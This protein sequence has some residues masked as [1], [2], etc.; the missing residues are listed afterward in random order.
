MRP[1]RPR[2]SIAPPSAYLAG[3]CSVVPHSSA[4]AGT[5]VTGTAHRP[6]GDPGTLPRFNSVLGA[7]PSQSS[8]QASPKEDERW[9]ELGDL[10]NAEQM[11]ASVTSMSADLKE[12]KDREDAAKAAK[13]A[14]AKAVREA[15]K[16]ARKA[17]QSADSELHT[18]RR[19]SLKS[20]TARRPA[21]MKPA[22]KKPAAKN[23]NAPKTYKRSRHQVEPDEELEADEVRPRPI[24]TPPLSHSCTACTASR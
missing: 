2:R 6:E 14:A 12:K 22:A 19:S 18:I 24:P 8:S 11:A 10:D 16:G 1:A 13:A 3:V 21:A 15:K 5:N 7:L 23:S 17:A 9:E 20:A 4:D